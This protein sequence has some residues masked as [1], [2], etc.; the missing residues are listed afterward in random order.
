MN[1]IAGVLIGWLVAPTLGKVA[2]C[3]AW[4]VVFC[5]W[6]AMS[7]AEEEYSDWAHS[8]GRPAPRS[9]SVSQ[10]FYFIEFMTALVTS[11]VFAFAASWVQGKWFA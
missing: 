6:R 3:V 4:S 9:G 2:T 11:L 1:V 8:T 10:D 7:G 5:V